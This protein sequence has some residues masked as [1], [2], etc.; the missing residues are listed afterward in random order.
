[1]TKKEA[2]K[3][4]RSYLTAAI[5]SLPDDTEYKAVSVHEDFTSRRERDHE[6]QGSLDDL[7]SLHVIELMVEEDPGRQK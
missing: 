2:A 3:Q 6:E 7:G 4:L 5:R 1:M